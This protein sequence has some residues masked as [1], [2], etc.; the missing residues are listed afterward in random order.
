MFVYTSSCTKNGLVACTEKA[1]LP[2]NVLDGVT[3]YNISLVTA[4]SC[5]SVTCP[6]G[7]QC[8]VYKPTGETF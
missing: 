4:D 5:A 6:T 8:E 2:G 1:C 3:W 7:S